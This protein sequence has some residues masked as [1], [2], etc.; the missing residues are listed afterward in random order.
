[1]HPLAFFL[2]GA[3][4]TVVFLAM[5]VAGVTLAAREERTTLRNSACWRVRI[6]TCIRS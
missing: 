3:G 5:I 6:S 4:F 2:T 1:M